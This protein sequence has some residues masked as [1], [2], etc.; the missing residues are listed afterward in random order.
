EPEV[1][2]Q[3]EGRSQPLLAVPALF[4]GVAELREFRERALCRHQSILRL[5]SRS[6]RPTD[7]P[8]AA[9]ERGTTTPTFAGC[10]LRCCTIRSTTRR[11]AT[12]KPTKPTTET[13][14]PGD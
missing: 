6:D 1:P 12:T 4:V 9:G 7:N 5:T 2:E 14:P 3:A 8:C 10:S 11:S 13:T